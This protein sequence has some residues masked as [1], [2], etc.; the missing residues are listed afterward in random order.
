MCDHPQQMQRVRMLRSRG[1]DLTIEM[2]RFRQA[3][4]LMVPDA[5]FEGLLEGHLGHQRGSRSNVAR[6]RAALQSDMWHR[7]PAGCS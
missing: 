6:S 1:E 4:G 3:P 7:L 2:F 5:R